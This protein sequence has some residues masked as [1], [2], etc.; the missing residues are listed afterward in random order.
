MLSVG[1]TSP[2][3]PTGPIAARGWAAVRLL[4][5]PYLNGTDSQG[6]VLRGRRN[7]VVIRREGG[8]RP[9]SSVEVPDGQ[10]HL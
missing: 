2:P 10:I 3:L 5:H 9:R 6:D 7:V 1:T 8:R 4:L